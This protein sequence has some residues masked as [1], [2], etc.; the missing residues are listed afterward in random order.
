[1]EF[2]SGQ[3]FSVPLEQKVIQ[4]SPLAW[5]NCNS[6]PLTSCRHTLP[7]KWEERDWDAVTK[8][9]NANTGQAWE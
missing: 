1:M 2:S 5:A 6:T 8:V 3:K 9:R 4:C 7:T